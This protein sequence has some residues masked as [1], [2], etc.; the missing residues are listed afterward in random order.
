MG[1]IGLILRVGAVTACAGSRLQ[2]TAAMSAVDTRRIA[3]DMGRDPSVAGR[4]TGC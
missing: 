3:A 4:S 2:P 1:L